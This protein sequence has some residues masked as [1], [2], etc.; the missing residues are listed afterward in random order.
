MDCSDI[1]FTRN[2][3][4][5]SR[6]TGPARFVLTGTLEDERLLPYRQFHTGIQKNP[7]MIHHIRVNLEISLK[8][9]EIISASAEMPC[10]PDEDCLGIKDSVK[11]L[12]GLRISR[13]FTK[14]VKDVMGESK[15]CVHMTNLVQS[16]G[17]AAV[18]ALWAFYSTGKVDKGARSESAE[19]SLLLN[20]CWLWRPGGPYVEKLWAAK[21]NSGAAGIGGGFTEKKSVITIDGPSGAGK[22]TISRLVADCLS[23]TYL[24]TGA[25]YRAVALC[26]IQKGIS[27]ED[28][29]GLANLCRSLRL[30]FKKGMNGVAVFSENH[31]ISREIR[32]EEVGMMA[33]RISALPEVRH[34]LLELQRSF[35]GQGGLVAEGRDMGTVVFPQAKLKIYLDAAPAE[36]A[37]RRYLELL[38]KGIEAD[39][40]SIE[41]DII[42]RDRQDTERDTAPLR[43]ANGS[44]V[45]D[46]TGLSLR[47]VVEKIMELAR[48]VGLMPQTAEGHK[49]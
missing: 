46:S 7:G 16:M 23:F 1:F 3:S 11:Q 38:E 10:V 33:S 15:G 25:I 36:R 34:C 17:S 6:K 31:D 20:S 29:A 48:Q 28:S 24:D 41:A 32:T 37:R 49:L 19:Q 2:I 45:V 26:A 5:T 27:S 9:L 40:K 44:I 18:Q 12:V 47:E 14:K 21:D 22:S 4:I 13:G 43:P 30:E 8:G 42:K 39:Y 35:A